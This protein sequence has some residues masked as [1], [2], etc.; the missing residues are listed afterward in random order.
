MATEEGHPSRDPLKCNKKHV[1]SKKARNRRREEEKRNNNV[2]GV[3]EDNVQFSKWANK[4]GSQKKNSQTWLLVT[5]AHTYA[6]TRP[7]FS[8]H[9][10]HHDSVNVGGCTR[11]RLAQVRGRPL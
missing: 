1:D 3:N 10:Y 11:N 9:S 7:L 8:T 2:E 4:N 6:K 5:F